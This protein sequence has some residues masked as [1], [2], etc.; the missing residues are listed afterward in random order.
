V[1]I[2]T[3]FPVFASFC[4]KKIILGLFVVFLFF[5]DVYV[6]ENLSGKECIRLQKMINGIKTV[7][8]N[9]ADKT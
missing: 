2:I 1:L 8:E 9:K 4:A 6:S 3:L 7:K 5:L